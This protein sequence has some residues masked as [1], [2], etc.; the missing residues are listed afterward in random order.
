M[1]NQ[2]TTNPVPTPQR[3]WS[4][5]KFADS[6][7]LWTGAI[8]STGYGRFN[9]GP[10][11]AYAHRWAYEFCIGSIPDGLTLDHLCRVTRCVKP[12]HLEPVTYR[13][14]ILRGNGLSALAVRNNVCVAGHAFD[15][16]NTYVARNGKRHCRACKN[17][18]SMQYYYKRR[19][20]PGA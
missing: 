6:C 19:E 8:G 3:F 2:H 1:P 20:A 5:V 13:A 9:A 11:T 4:K 12:D 10:L 16:A 14:N 17:R 18:R 7:W 15:S